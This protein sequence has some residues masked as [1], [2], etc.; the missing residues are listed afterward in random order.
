[1]GVVWV[2]AYLKGEMSEVLRERWVENVIR[3]KRHVLGERR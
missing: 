2:G 1:M 3:V